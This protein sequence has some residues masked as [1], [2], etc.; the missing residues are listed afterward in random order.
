MNL[1]TNSVILAEPIDD[2]CAA[3]LSALLDCARFR[4]EYKPAHRA[5]LFLS[6]DSL[7]NVAFELR[8]LF[9]KTESDLN[10]RSFLAK[11][12]IDA[13]SVRAADLLFRV[14]RAEALEGASTEV[15]HE[16]VGRMI[17]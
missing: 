1:D 7:K 9:G 4:Y 14:I 5:S 3:W 12:V 2:R 10:D 6:H 15:M 17:P 16:R 8:R 13:E 11:I